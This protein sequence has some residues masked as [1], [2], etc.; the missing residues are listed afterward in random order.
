VSSR[1]SFSAEE[2][3]FYL[4]DGAGALLNARLRSRGIA[5]G[6]TVTITKVKVVSSNALRPVTSTSHSNARP[7]D[8]RA[9]MTERAQATFR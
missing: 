2:G 1:R 4:P 8:G 7:Y 6:D 5:A 3:S 9:P